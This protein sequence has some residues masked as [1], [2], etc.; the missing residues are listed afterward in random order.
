[1]VTKEVIFTALFTAV[2]VVGLNYGLKKMN[3]LQ[4]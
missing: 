1:M 4:A 3:V 2:L